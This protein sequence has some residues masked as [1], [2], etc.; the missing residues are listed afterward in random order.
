MLL[1]KNWTEPLLLFIAVTLRKN[2]L[3]DILIAYNLLI[4]FKTII[5]KNEFVRVALH[6]NSLSS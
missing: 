3:E 2:S 1:F 6:N 4:N 5:Y